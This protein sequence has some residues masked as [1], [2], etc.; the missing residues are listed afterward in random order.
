M[1]R[2]RLLLGAIVLA[3]IIAA[4]IAWYLISPL[5]ITR[6]VDEAFPAAQVAMQESK[7]D[8]MS[9]VTMQTP[10]PMKESSDQMQPQTPEPMKESSD[11]MQMSPTTQPTATQQP[12][13]MAE[14]P[15][16][17]ATQQPDMMAETPEPTAMQQPE[18]TAEKPAEMTAQPTEALSEPKLLRSGDFHPVTHEGTGTASI[19]ELPDGTRVL[20]LE[21]F[22]VLN[23][24]DLYVWLS[25]APDADNAR[26]ILDNQYAEIGRL[27]GNQGNQNYE[28]PADLDVSAFNSVTIWCRR[29]SV[30]F[31]TA[32]LK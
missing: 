8:S 11:Q 15:E 10:E 28:L 14:T 25:A 4:P 19:Y 18:P 13:P 7:N 17:I 2:K 26:T 22:E 32:P 23:G 31:A 20:R 12:E 16:P 24:P 3:A 9:V 21:N 29:F 30:N 6:T 1:T 5:F 27:K